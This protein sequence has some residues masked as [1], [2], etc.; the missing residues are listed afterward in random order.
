LPHKDVK[1][2]MRKIQKKGWIVQLSGDSHYKLTSPTG[3]V[4]ITGSSPSPTNFRNM[5]AQLKR[6]GY[7]E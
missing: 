7:G 2:L 1:A 3:Q 6:M 5:K 4:T